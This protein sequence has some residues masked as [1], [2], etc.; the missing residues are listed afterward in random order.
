MNKGKRIWT[1][2]KVEMEFQ[3][4]LSK[5]EIYRVEWAV[6]SGCVERLNLKNDENPG[7]GI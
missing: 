2:N 1:K 6:L 7:E 5:G 4:M 3:K